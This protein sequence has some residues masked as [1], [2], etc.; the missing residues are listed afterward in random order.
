[1]IAPLR[2]IAVALTFALLTIA[3]A[4]SQPV[5][6]PGSGTAA[7]PK[8]LGGEWEVRYIDDSAMKLTLLHEHITLNAGHGPL[9]IP[10]REI[11]R[12]EFGVRLGDVDQAKLEQALSLVAGK[13]SAKREQGKEAL[14]E[15]GVRILPFVRR[16]MKSAD[17][18]AL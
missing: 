7:K 10:L 11:R 6:T 18:D 5:A 14:L 17:A 16:A 9:Q 1:M 12:I 2:S 3:P 4:T 13:D 15:M 8:P